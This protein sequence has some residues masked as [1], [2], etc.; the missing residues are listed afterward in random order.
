[1]I[2]SV[3]TLL[4]KRHKQRMLSLATRSYLSYKQEVDYGRFNEAIKS[5]S[6]A[7]TDPENRVH[8]RATES[9]HHAYT[10]IT[11]SIKELPR[12]KYSKESQTGRTIITMLLT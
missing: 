6:R 3:G 5:P 10:R 9:K 1:M 2:V 12:L 11:T 4:K 8:L 7:T